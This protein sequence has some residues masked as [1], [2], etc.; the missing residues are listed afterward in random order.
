M[1]AQ[2]ER[3]VLAHKVHQR[4]Q[5]LDAEMPLDAPA[6]GQASPHSGFQPLAPFEILPL[7]VNVGK[8]DHDGPAAEAVPPHVQRLLPRQHV[9]PKP[10]VLNFSVER[11]VSRPVRLGDVQAL[12]GARLQRRAPP[13]AH[14]VTVFENLHL[15]LERPRAQ[16]PVGLAKH[17][18]LGDLH[19]PL[20]LL[21]PDVEHK[22]ALVSSVA[23]E[24]V[25]LL[26]AV[27]EVEDAAP[28]VEAIPARCE[29]HAELLTDV[30]GARLLGQILEILL[31]AVEFTA[32][33]G[34]YW[35]ACRQ[36]QLARQAR[37]HGR[38]ALGLP[39]AAGAGAPAAAA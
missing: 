15:A 20:P 11:V 39:P 3:G 13:S 22:G 29:R 18:Y 37:Q 5:E 34:E 7:A 31:R 36:V 26:G 19:A 9:V 38:L 6:Y 32:L 21:D 35:A 12:P 25:P 4:G 14:E 30:Q 2:D 33:V 17:D 8:I 23:D 16:E 24:D 1:G 28:P 10:E 27:P